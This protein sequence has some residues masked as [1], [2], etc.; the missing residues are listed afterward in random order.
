MQT[1][2]SHRFKN[3]QDAGRRLAQ[4][5]TKFAQLPN[6]IILAFPNGGIPVAMEISKALDKPFDV[7]LVREVTL[8]ADGKTVLGT[9][10][11]GG[12]RALICDLIDRM[13]LSQSDVSEAVLRESVELARREKIYRGDHPSLDVADQ[14]V[15]LV[16]DGVTP[17]SAF[18]DAIRLLRRQ[19]VERIVV[20]VPAASR[21]ETCDLRAEA[22]EVVALAESDA[23]SSPE[24]WFKNFTRAT[25]AKV[26]R[27]LAK[28]WP[29]LSH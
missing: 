3:R 7:L 4:R 20:A 11:S 19:H 13:H 8:L 1:V 29:L 15:I 10:T 9:I 24:K 16:D 12:V 21:N 18:R 5:L 27:L 6:V 14:T 26:C 28:E 2:I 23:C 25:D 17:C 22:D